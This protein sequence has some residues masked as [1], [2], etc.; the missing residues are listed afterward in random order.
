MTT[1][2]VIRPL[3]PSEQIFAF[4]E[5]FVGY[6]ARVTGRLDLAALT[7]AFEAVLRARPVLTAVLEPGDG[8]GHTLLATEADEP[9]MTIVD[10][11]PEQLLA[12]ADLDQRRALC[13]LSV[14]RGT[15]ST[16]VTLLTHH[17]IADATHSL[18]L[19]HDI[20]S[21]Y[22]IARTAGRPQLPDRGYP[23]TVEE[24]LTVRGVTKFSTDDADSSLA[25][26]PMIPSAQADPYPTLVT[27]RCL[28]SEERTAA[29]VALGHREGLTVHSL[30]SAAL[31]LTEAEARKTPVTE[32]V[33]SYSVDLRSRVRPSIGTTE[34]TNVLGFADYLPGTGT[35]TTM[36]AL[37]RGVG[38]AL[39][40]DLASGYIQQTPL[41][42]PDMAAEPPP[43]N[44]STVIATNWGRI[45]PPPT[46]PELGVVD[47][48][49]TMISKADRTGRRP[50]EPGGGTTIVSTYNGRLSIEIH[51][52]PEF[53]SVQ[54][55]RIS[56]L[57]E[58]LRG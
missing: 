33:C 10:G 54:Q 2:T 23:T 3:A 52:P 55:P 38:R 14:V 6:S 43:S 24:L 41:Q 8:Y 9:P 30:V 37:A 28:L 11:D 13:R 22:N 48:R 36:I 56:Q 32:L 47:F 35:P 25:S 19:F 18:A 4:G 5:V 26:T 58:L 39:R 20:W 7:T 27:S 44:I 57:T 15:N 16:A 46:P 50:V 34:G 53:T 21:C 49:T 31:L 45:P 40:A 51:H 42:L 29:L 17:S 1:A 12:G